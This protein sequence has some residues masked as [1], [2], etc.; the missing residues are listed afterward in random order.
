MG[1]GVGQ[2]RN[3]RVNMHDTHRGCAIFSAFFCTALLLQA[4]GGNRPAASTSSDHIRGTIQRV[5]G[6]VVAIEPGQTADLQPGVHVFVVAHRNAQGVFAADR[7]LA[8]KNGVV[9]PI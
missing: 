6:Q 5:D 7:V 1:L 4:C 9:P 3:V 8:G 2:V